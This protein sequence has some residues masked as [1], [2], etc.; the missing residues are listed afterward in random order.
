IE[1][2]FAGID[3]DTDRGTLRH[4]RRSLPCDANLE[5]TTSYGQGVK[6]AVTEISN[7]TRLDLMPPQSANNSFAARSQA[8]QT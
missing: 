5:F 8:T 7:A 1:L 4:L 6:C 2:P 3:P